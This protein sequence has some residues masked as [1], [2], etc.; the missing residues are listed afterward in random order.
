MYYDGKRVAEDKA[1]ETPSYAGLQLSRDVKVELSSRLSRLVH[2][3]N[4][5]LSQ[6]KREEKIEL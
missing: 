4:V 3:A 1:A 2:P 6:V 5:S